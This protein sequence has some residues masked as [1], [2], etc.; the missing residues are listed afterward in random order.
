MLLNLKSIFRLPDIFESFDF[1]IYSSAEPVLC[2][3][4]KP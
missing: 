1:I 3:P 4:V 2:L